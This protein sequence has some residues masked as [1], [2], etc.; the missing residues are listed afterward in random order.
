MSYEELIETDTYKAILK[1]QIRLAE[2]MDKKIVEILKNAKKEK[3][4]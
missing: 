4:K 2:A 1:C 3:D